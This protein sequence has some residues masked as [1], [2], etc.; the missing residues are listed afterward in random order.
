MNKKLIALDL[1][2]TTLNNRSEISVRTKKVLTTLRNAGHLVSIVTGR[3]Y[4]NSKQFYAQLGME[5]P[6]V[7]FNGAL[8]HLPD[9]LNWK[10][11]YHKTLDREIALDML[12]LKKEL[13]I[14]L[15]AAELRDTVFADNYF[16]PYNDFFPEGKT[17]T[18]KLTASSLKEDPTAICVFTDAE[19]QTY[20]TERILARYGDSVEVRTWGGQSPCL[21]IVAAGVQKAL[22]VERIAQVYGIK[23]KDIMAFGDEDN[24]YEMIQY[25][26]HG[27]VMKNGI[28]AL[29][30]ISNDITEKTN[31]EDGL[32]HYLENYFSLV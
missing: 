8:C 7:N 27:V 11:Q 29:K 17:G 31:D 23:Q 13:D 12:T 24:D 21:E 30:H 5:T 14:H 25:A 32:A 3:P 16:V 1:D 2:G 10:S 19:N 18:S 26:G 4:R 28:D 6:I 22:G 20:I 15:I 9:Q